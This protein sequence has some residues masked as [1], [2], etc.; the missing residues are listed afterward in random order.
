MTAR[1]III[2]KNFPIW[3]IYSTE[4]KM[5]VNRLGQED[6]LG[7]LTL[8]EAQASLNFILKGY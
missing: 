6:T 5:Y 2:Q 3:S 4:Q 7:F 1:Y 8:V